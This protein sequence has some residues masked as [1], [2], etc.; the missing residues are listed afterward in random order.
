MKAPSRGVHEGLCCDDGPAG[1]VRETRES[2]GSGH[3]GIWGLN[4]VLQTVELTCALAAASVM[5]RRSTHVARCPQEAGD[6]ILRADYRGEVPQ[7]R[8]RTT[9]SCSTHL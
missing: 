6:V 1:H 3:V 7:H 2:G 5:G 9:V 8:R 4:W